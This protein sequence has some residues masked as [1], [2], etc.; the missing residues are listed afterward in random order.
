M[1]TLAVIGAG[2]KGIAIAAKARALAAVGLDVP[3]VV[4]V[5]RGAVAGNWSGRQGYTNGILPLGTPPEKDVGFPY[6]ESWGAA[7]ASVTSAMA[8]FSWQRHLM[9]HGRYADW[10]DRGRMRPTHREWA[11]YLREVAERAEAEIVSGELV[12]LDVEGDRWRLALEGREAISADGVVFT[13]SGPPITVAG[14]PRDHPHVLDGRSYWL[15]GRALKKQIA[16]S[17]CVIGSGETAASIVISLVKQWHKR[18]TVDVLTSRGVLYSRGESYDE[19]RFYSDPGDWP[20]LAE[21]HR[22]EFLERTDRGVFSMQAEAILNQ[23]RGFRTLAGR[24]AAIEAGDRQVVVTIEYDDRR[25]RVAYDLVVV[26]IGFDARWFESLLGSEALRRVEDAAGAELERRIEVDL[27][28]AELFPPI[29]LPVLA[30][31]AQGPGFPNLSCLGLLSDRILRR[32]VPL[33]EPTPRSV[34]ERRELV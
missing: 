21:S 31:L 33:E 20:R 30:G 5:D 13:G 8:E 15:Q 19:N 27:S 11:A 18:S 4:L 3:K 6:P 34:S 24:A 9:A 2:P 10:V 32:Y 14:Q 29:H 25:E 22:R 12:G 1:P 16:E 17:V 26:A 28:V 23:S 7:S